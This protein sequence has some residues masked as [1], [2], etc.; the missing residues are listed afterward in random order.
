MIR[1]VGRLRTRRQ[2]DLVRSAQPTEDFS[3]QR[4][5]KHLNMSLGLTL[6]HEK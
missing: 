4:G 6:N 2:R 5:P 1:P 3:D